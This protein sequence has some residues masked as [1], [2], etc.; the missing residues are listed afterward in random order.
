MPALGRA[1]TLQAGPAAEP[2]AAR[3]TRTR[4]LGRPASVGST[5]PRRSARPSPTRRLGRARVR[6]SVEPAPVESRPVLLGTSRGRRP[7]GPPL[8]S[9]RPPPH[10]GA[11]A[12][13]RVPAVAPGGEPH[14]TRVPSGSAAATRVPSPPRAA[15]SRLGGVRTRAWTRGRWGSFRVTRVRYPCPCGAWSRAFPAHPRGCVARPGAGERPATSCPQ[16]QKSAPSGEIRPTITLCSTRV[17]LGPHPG[18]NPGTTRPSCGPNGR[19]R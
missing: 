15:R 12:R 8:G 7:S 19:A 17:Q 10:P 2:T 6:G 5:V 3:R 18:I 13:P 1:R 11:R 4:R 9:D 16:A 14:R